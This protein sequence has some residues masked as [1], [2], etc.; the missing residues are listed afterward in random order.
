[1]PEDNLKIV[2]YGGGDDESKR[3]RNPRE[4]PEGVNTVEYPRSVFAPSMEGPPGAV[5]LTEI[6]VLDL[7]TEGEA[8]GLV[9]GTYNY[10]GTVGNT[11][12]DE[13][14]F[15][16]FD[17]APGTSNR[18]LRSVYWNTVPVV[19][20]QNKFNFQN[21]EMG[22]A[23]GGPNGSITNRI[24]TD[25][26]VS[27]AISERLR[28]GPNFAKT[29]RILNKSCKGAEINIKFTVLST[30]VT[31]PESNPDVFVYGDVIKTAVNYIIRWKALY[32]TIGKTPTDYSKFKVEQ[33][34]GKISYGY[35]WSTT[36]NFV[37]TIGNA[38]LEPD[39]LGW[40]VYIERL[41]EDSKVSSLRNQ[42]F[43]DSIT[44]IYGDVLSFPNS[45]IVATK[46]SAEFFAQIP[47]RA[48][49]MHLLKVRIPNNYDPITRKYGAIQAYDSDGIGYITDASLWDGDWKR[50]S[51][52]DILKQWTNNPAWCYYDLLTN[53][54]YGLGNYIDEDL[55]DKWSLYKIAQYCDVIVA[56]GFGGV[57]PR[58]TCNT[59]L[60]SREEAYK[61]INDMASVF[62]AMTYY[63]GGSIF[64]VADAA[65]DCKYQFTNANVEGGDFNYSSSSKRVRHSIAVVRY[66]D[67]ENFYQPAIEYV[68][69]IG[70]IRRYGIREVEATSFACT[71]RG[72]A[73]RYGRWI[74]L[75]EK[76]NTE[77]INF[78]ASTE[79][80]YLRPGDVFKVYDFNRKGKRYAGRVYHFTSLSGVVLDSQPEG[81]LSSSTYTL[82]LLTPTY[83][84]DTTQTELSDSSETSDI[85]RPFI[86]KKNFLGSHIVP[87]TGA[88]DVV[89]SKINFTSPFNATD[90][91]VTGNL[92]W[93]V[94]GSGNAADAIYDNF[95]YFQTLRVEE[96]DDNKY[97]VNGLEY[98]IDKYAAIENDLLFDEPGLALNPSAPINLTLNARQVTI[99]SKFI[100][101]TFTPA[102]VSGVSSFSVYAKNTPFSDP[103]DFSG[104]N[105]LINVLPR[106]TYTGSYLPTADGTYYFRVY[107]SNKVGKKSIGYASNSITVTNIHPIRDISISSLMIEADA[108]ESNPAGTRNTGQ[109]ITASPIFSWQVGFNQDIPLSSNFDYRITFREPSP[110]NTPSQNIYF[111]VTGYHPD[112]NDIRYTF[113]IADNV[114]R[115]EDNYPNF[116]IITPN[117]TGPFR[118][119]DV[120]VEAIDTGYNS[121][122]G[123]NLFNGATRQDASYSNNQGYDILYANN[124]RFEGFHFYTGDNPNPV[125]YTT[126]QW[127]STDGDIKMSL[128]GT[129]DNDLA[130]GFLYYSPTLFTVNEVNAGLVPNIEFFN[131]LSS[132]IIIPVGLTGV[133]MAYIATKLYDVFDQELATSGIGIINSL[134]LSNV[135]PVR[136]RGAVDKA[137]LFSKWAEIPINF[138]NGTIGDWYNTSYGIQDVQTSISSVSYADGASSRIT[139]TVSFSEAMA[140]NNYITLGLF[141]PSAKTTTSVTFYFDWNHVVNSLR[142]SNAPDGLHIGVGTLKFNFGILANGQPAI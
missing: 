52:G 58:F 108:E 9:S 122:A 96:K 136:K 132:P 106:F 119:Y 21:V 1:M 66:N 3:Q 137:K 69:D 116:P 5:S 101:Y 49:D 13:V 36:I 8:E 125:S 54:R 15:T 59:I 16:P 45:A 94:E 95:Q 11:G 130:G 56:D 142:N 133:D 89:R 85:Q 128:S 14:T 4:A 28:Y 104:S 44:E 129:I 47:N 62:R 131:V 107:S 73:Q 72:Q 83:N 87:F 32:S 25:L 42:T 112:G 55:V 20:N 113:D 64:A 75:S 81:L 34:D 90:Y 68:E 67:A 123:G 53:R 18:F 86:Q 24:K 115:A 7:V 97:V 109:Y 17:A 50:D 29:Y 6:E 124:P 10:V 41:T 91:T 135:V 79:G 71:S 93:M 27:R 74:L 88:D 40:E 111:E 43:V 70:S 46:F 114:L 22:W 48:Y 61:V 60:T 19:N 51:V 80:A 31:A 35:I 98:D 117:R 2:G 77:T 134:N 118:S 121:S 39:F 141:A 65:R 37:S 120:V 26:T 99:N 84:Y 78:T 33:V 110:N 12:Y 126:D 140:N 63:A 38:I 103:A 57:E 82:S 23:A 138:T 139:L 30:T 127:I 76:L 105:Y 100:D 92:V 102:T